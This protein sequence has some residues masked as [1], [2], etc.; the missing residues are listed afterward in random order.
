MQTD[1]LDA[2]E[3]HREDAE[4]LFQTQ[5]WANAD[6][7]YGIAAECGLKRLMLAFGMPYDTSNDRPAIGSD[8]KHAD[9][10]WA[11]YESYR[12]GHH[13]GAGYALTTPNPFDDWDV[14]QRYAHRSNFNRDRVEAHRSGAEAVGQLIQKARWEG[15]I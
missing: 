9:I 8:R 2:H 7:L 1:Y 11:R 14:G 12:C 3:R 5:H 15:L 13:L 6:H 4:L 10:L